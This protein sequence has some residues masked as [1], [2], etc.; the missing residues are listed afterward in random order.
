M[1]EMPECIQNYVAEYLIERIEMILKIED[2]SERI[3]IIHIYDRL[4]EARHFF[5][6]GRFWRHVLEDPD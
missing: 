2:Y 5:P 1:D 4:N 6:P 3:R